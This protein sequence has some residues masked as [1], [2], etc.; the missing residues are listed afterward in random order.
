MRQRIAAFFR[1]R[2]WQVR[3]RALRRRR[4]D[5]RRQ[6]QLGAPRRA[7]RARRLRDHR[8]RHDDLLGARLL[9]RD[10]GAHRPNGRRSR[11]RTRC[12]GSTTSPT[13]SHPIMTKS[14]MVYQPIDYVSHVTVTGNDGVRQADDRARQPSD[15]RRRHALLPGELRLRDRVRRDARYGRRDAALSARTLLEGESLDIA[16]TDAQRASTT[17]SSP[18][19]DKQSGMPTADPRVNNP[20]VVLDVA[21]G[22]APVGAALVPLHTSIDLGDGWRVTPAAVPALQRL[23]VSLRPGHSA[24]RD[25]RVRA[26]RRADHLVLLPAR[27]AR[28]CASTTRR[29]ATAAALAWPRRP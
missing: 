13:R 4:V 29:P 9:G 1:A 28:T 24:R 22:G 14:G 6:A 25:R 21:Q 10:R 12:C 19:V 20:G 7:G 16:G 18:T 23:S 17:A 2:G 26:A 3:E 27:A 8:R 5:L 15:R 11:R